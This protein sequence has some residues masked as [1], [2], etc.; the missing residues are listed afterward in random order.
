[1]KK[2]FIW[3]F[4]VGGK[5]ISGIGETEQDAFRNARDADQFTNPATIDQA[6]GYNTKVMAGPEVSQAYYDMLAKREKQRM[7]Q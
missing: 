4:L 1:M 7:T 2:L 5:W 3:E 6:R